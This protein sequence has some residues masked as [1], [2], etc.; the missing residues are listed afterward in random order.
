MVALTVPSMAFSIGTNPQSTS[1]PATASS[2]VVM[3]PRGVRAATARS[4]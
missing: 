3:D 1:P 2:T 4:A